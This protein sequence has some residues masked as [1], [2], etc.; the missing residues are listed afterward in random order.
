MDVSR[1]FERFFTGIN[2]WESKS[3]INMWKNFD[4]NVIEGDFQ[5]LKEAGIT[6]LRV[7]PL[8][9]EFQPL[10]AL[11][12]PCD[13]YE[14][15]FGEDPLPDTPAGRAGV[16]ETACEKF[17]QFC[18]LAQKY[19]MKLIVALITGHM[20]FRTYTPPA[21]GG[22]AILG[23]PTVMKWQLRFVK[24]FVKRFRDEPAILGWD[25]GNEPANLPG[26]T[27]NPDTFYVWCSVI[28]DAV[29]SCDDSHPVISGM[30][31]S[32]IEGTESNYKTIGE[33]CDIHTEHPY[34]IFETKS[35]PL[36]TMKPILDIPFRC[37]MGGDIGN[38]P[39]FV[40]EFG[41][42]GY[43]NCSARSEADF[44]RASLYTALAHGCHG[45]MWWC[46][47]DQGHLDYAPY[48][49]NTIGSDY[50]FFDKDGAAKPLVSENLAFR[51]NLSRIPGGVL[52]KHAACGTI[53]VPRD[54]GTLDYET[55]RAVYML[56]K[57]ANLDLNFH[58]SLDPIKPSLLYLLASIGG[59]KSIPKHRLDEVLRQVRNGAVLYLSADTGLFRQIPEITG[60]SIA[61]REAVNAEKIITFSGQRLPVKTTYFYKPESS[62]AEILA[63]DENGD[64]VFF[65]NKYGKGYV[66]FLTVPLE[67]YLAYKPGAF[68]GEDLPPYSIIYR[69]IAACAGISRAADSDN[70]Y[71]RLTEHPI[72]ENTRYVFA[73]N[74]HNKIECANLIQNGSY[75]VSVVFGGTYDN[76][77][78]RLKNNDAILLRL[79]EREK[80]DMV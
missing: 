52:P 65:K 18:R 8:W 76:G 75:D 35:D 24:Y 19:D 34:N 5:L 4:I 10:H 39:T 20:S 71:I 46:A 37:K 13:V 51:E 30:A 29:K 27:S 60:V 42:I 7:F 63:R 36:A 26:G 31:R 73:I 25:L 2:Y 49:W 33:M 79:A 44:Y 64:G 12:G 58:Y 3:A 57:Q 43:M 77:K 48:R 66:Y 6:H 72:D 16:S 78:I 1:I 74:Y 61:Y 80:S 53:L 41:S 32:G 22:K 9:S 28:A 70:P 14:Y 21:F 55:L 56:A 47:F 67:K 38:I 15:S 59:H 17:R 11:Y 50:G 40:Q 45:T 54:D 68:Y 23:D 69:E 62:E